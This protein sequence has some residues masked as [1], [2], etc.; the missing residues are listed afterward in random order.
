VKSIGKQPSK[1]FSRQEILSALPEVF[2]LPLAALSDRQIKNVMT[3]DSVREILEIY[4]DCLQ[5][6]AA[7]NVTHG[8]LH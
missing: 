2:G 5:V 6:L 3:T 1:T 4:L 7:L 8:E